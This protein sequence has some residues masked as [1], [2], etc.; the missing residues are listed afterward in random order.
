MSDGAAGWEGGWE[1]VAAR[2]QEERSKADIGATTPS[3]LTRVLYIPNHDGST[4]H[5][6]IHEITGDYKDTVG[7][8]MMGTASYA[9]SL[10]KIPKPH[11]IGDG[12]ATPF[13]NEILYNV[14]FDKAGD[15]D[16]PVTS[17]LVVPSSSQ[18]VPV[19]VET[20]VYVYSLT[21]LI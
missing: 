13:E 8:R 5:H 21:S 17:V 14:H 3:H 10:G 19:L 15:R 16:A 4:S 7:N 11:M 9:V 20:D 2:N 6:P 12:I 1:I 18:S